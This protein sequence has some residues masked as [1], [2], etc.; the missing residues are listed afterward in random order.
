MNEI[1]IAGIVSTLAGLAI[2][3][4]ANKCKGDL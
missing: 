4:I 2:A 1:I 3:I